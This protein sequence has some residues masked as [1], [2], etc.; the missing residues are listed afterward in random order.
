MIGSLVRVSRAEI[1]IRSLPTTRS[2]ILAEL[3]LHTPLQVEA[4]TG[5]WYRVATPDGTI[6]FVAA[7]LTEPVDG[8]VRHEVV[9]SGAMLLTEPTSTA[10]AVDSVAAG[11][12][13]PVLGAF[14]EFLFVEGPSGRAGWLPAY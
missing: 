7:R 6:G 12:E 13:V 5:T 10:V 4:G 1:R 2:S 9:A 3:P 11:A 14:G 8:P